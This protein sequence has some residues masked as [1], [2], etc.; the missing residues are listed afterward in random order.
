MKIIP[1]IS[2]VLLTTSMKINNIEKSGLIY[3]LFKLSKEDL[4]TKKVFNVDFLNNKGS[5]VRYY[6]NDEIIG[7]ILYKEKNIDAIF[8]S[9][10]LPFDGDIDEYY[11][12][13]PYEFVKKDEY[14]Y[15]NSDEI[16]IN[17]NSIIYDDISVYENDYFKIYNK[18]SLIYT[19]SS[20]YLNETKL[21]N[22]PNYMNTMFDNNGCVSTTAAMYFSYLYRN[23]T[24]A[25]NILTS[26]L[27]LKHTDDKLAVDNFIYS[28]GLNYFN[29][30]TEGTSWSDIVPGYNKY[31]YSRNIY[32]FSCKEYKPSYVSYNSLYNFILNTANPFQVSLDYKKNNKTIRHATLGIGVKSIFDGNK[33]SY[34]IDV[35]AV[36]DNVMTEVSY[37]FD[38]VRSFYF[39]GR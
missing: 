38:Y 27:P 17:S 25:S 21:L 30:T 29:T 13:T 18:N 9:D 10:Y 33:N 6:N 37:V 4:I 14:V 28:L 19:Y 34:F 23:S 26:A 7:S 8:Y 5:F 20:S 3:D 12:I 11:C 31:L 35:N 39:L 15:T 36:K 2:V 1:L 16:F 24:Q 22:V 32:D